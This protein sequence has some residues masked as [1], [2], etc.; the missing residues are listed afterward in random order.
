MLRTLYLRNLDTISFVR[1]RN[2]DFD[3]VVD[4]IRRSGTD[5]LSHF[6]NNYAHEGGLSLQQNPNEFAALICFLKEHVMK[7][8]PILNYLEI[9]SGS[10]GTCL[11]LNQEVG[12]K[13]IFSLDDGKHPRASEQ[14]K[15]FSHVIGLR[16]F[17]GDSHSSE[18]K[19]YLLENLDGKIDVAFID[20]D[21]SYLGVR[22]DLELV[23][24]FCKAGTI[25]IFHDTRACAG[26]E[27]VWIE[28]VK[29]KHIKP[30]AEYTGTERTLGIGVGE[31]V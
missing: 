19:Q 30:I 7:A 20:G 11:L 10:G 23:L 27:N 18:A 14:K 28:S 9:G 15:N 22:E 26:V 29:S 4:L 31:V 8:G 24:P 1:S 2:N 16:Q 13:N 3:R 6:G 5:D 12:F 21:H 17:I 25:I